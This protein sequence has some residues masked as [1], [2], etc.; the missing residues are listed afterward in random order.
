MTVLGGST[1]LSPGVTIQKHGHTY[2]ERL[3]GRPRYS[4]TTAFSTPT[5]SVSI[6][7]RFINRRSG[8]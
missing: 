1:D 3:E 5:S 8:Q 4:A 2:W 6:V 7:T